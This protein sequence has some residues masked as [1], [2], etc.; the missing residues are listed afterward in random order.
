MNLG[1]MLTR[2]ASCYPE[3]TALV[4]GDLRLR[5]EPL[6]GTDLGPS[7]SQLCRTLYQRR[8][9]AGPGGEGSPRRVI[10]RLRVYLPPSHSLAKTPDVRGAF[11]L[12]RGAVPLVRKKRVI[13]VDDVLTTG[14][15][16][17][18]CAGVLVSA[19]AGEI[20][21]ASAAIAP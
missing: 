17:R 14:A 16:F 15:T 11:A 3:K 8:H 5:Y 18:A 2:N 10:P 1:G 12:K 7:S 6:G 4:F 20:L 21:A 9:P 13:L 19:G